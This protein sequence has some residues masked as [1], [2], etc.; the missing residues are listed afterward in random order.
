MYIGIDYA[1]KPSEVKKQNKTK[2]INLA[3]KRVRLQN[4][5]TNTSTSS[6]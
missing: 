2:R 6:H 3:T 5:L 1:P 4:D